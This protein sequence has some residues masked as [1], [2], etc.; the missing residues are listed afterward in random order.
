MRG[1]ELQ[2]GNRRQNGT[3]KA[4]IRL[5]NQQHRQT[6]TPDLSESVLPAARIHKTPTTTDRFTP[7]VMQN[8]KAAT[9]ARFVTTSY[10]IT[11]KW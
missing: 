8:V 3:C 7:Q 4:W 1:T 11:V 2:A 10:Q 5:H 6:L 9:P